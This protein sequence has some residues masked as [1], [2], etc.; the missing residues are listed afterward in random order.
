[1]PPKGE[2]QVP[3]RACPP[4]KPYQPPRVQEYGTLARLIR[5][6]AAGNL[7]EGVTTKPVGL[8]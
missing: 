2:K 3:Q 4:K 6:K 7:P 5:L 1:M 8:G